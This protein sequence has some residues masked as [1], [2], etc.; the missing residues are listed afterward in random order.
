MKR[1]SMLMMSFYDKPRKFR[2]STQ[3]RKYND[4]QT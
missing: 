3:D 2:I 4:G 1:E